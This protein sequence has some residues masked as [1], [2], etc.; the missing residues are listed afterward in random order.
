MQ[1][2]LQSLENDNNKNRKYPVVDARIRET[3]AK[4][5]KATNKNALNDAYVKF[6]RW[7]SDRL[8][9]QDGIVCYVTNNSFVDQIAFD[10]MRK[11]LLNDFT[12]IYH[13]DLHGNVRKNP[14]LSGTT[15][16]VFGIQVGAG[17]TIAVRKSGAEKFLKYHRVPEDWRKTEKL[18]FLSAMGDMSQIAWRD[19]TPNIKQIWLTDGLQAD[20]EEF[21]P[22]GSKETKS[23]HNLEVKAIFKN[24]GGGVKTHRDAWVYNFNPQSLADNVK[25]FVVNYNSEVSRWKSEKNHH[26]FVDNFV[27]YDTEKLSWSMGLKMQMQ[28]GHFAEFSQHKVRSALYRPFTKLSLFFDRVIDEALYQFPQILPTASTEAENLV[29]IVGGYERKAFSVMLTQYIPDL[30]FFADP[31]QCFPLYTYAVDG[32]IRRD[33]VT[34]WA[35]AQFRAKYG[36]RVTKQDIF[37]YVYGLLHSPEYRERYK[38]N[39][40]RELPRVPL[41]G[42]EPTPQQAATLPEREGE[43]SD[44]ITG[45][46]SPDSASSRLGRSTR[47]EERAEGEVGYSAED[48]GA[49]RAFV[50]AG[51]ALAVLHIGYEEA[52]EYPLTQL[53]NKDVPFSWRVTKM[54]LNKEKTALV[55]NEALILGGI[56]P[57]VYDYKLGNRSAL[58]WVIDQYQVSTDKRSGIVTDPNRADDPEY[59][60]RLVRRVVTVSLETRRWVAGLPPLGLGVGEVEK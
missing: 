35:L 59:I 34:D 43:E 29:I 7:A 45:L 6:F 13:L 32:A 33:N 44:P 17:I 12:Q 54:R 22:I 16:N 36:P 8:G 23:Q 49:F 31:T 60:V 56:P 4:D 51:E 42:G 30:N 46:P 52:E 18:G 1:E 26:T 37:H 41:V 28:R 57:E 58:E 47:S 39:L 53:V 48:G 20:F 5:S 10:G 55:I 50:A 24:Y 40:K 21:P 25:R 2:T 27:M 11:N 3:Y 38:E 19:L 15:H 9:E 14:K